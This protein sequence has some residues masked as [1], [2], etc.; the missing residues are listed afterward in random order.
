MTK[1]AKVGTILW[2]LSALCTVLMAAP[3]HALDVAALEQFWSNLYPADPLFVADPILGPPE[4]LAKAEPD[5]CFNGNYVGEW[6]TWLYS[7]CP[8][9]PGP[10]TG[11]CPE[12][13]DPIPRPKVNQAYVW[14]CCQYAM[15]GSGRVCCSAGDTGTFRG[16]I[17]RVRVWIPR[18]G[19]RILQ[20]RRGLPM[21]RSLR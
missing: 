7:D 14:N 3:S 18:V 6:W 13:C 15:L 20:R 2:I 5:E 11:D 10:V 21:L 16:R 1:S 8:D 4:L 17:R 12:G 19:P 9:L